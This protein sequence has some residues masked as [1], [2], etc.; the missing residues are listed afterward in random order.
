MT[1]TSTLIAASPDGLPL[2]AAG[3]AC[4][5]RA[6]RPGA[7][8]GRGRRVGTGASVSG[9][10]VHRID[11]SPTRWSLCRMSRRR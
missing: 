1:G 3:T 11:D 4:C 5:A 7:G 8:S 9:P 6:C 2:A 10:A